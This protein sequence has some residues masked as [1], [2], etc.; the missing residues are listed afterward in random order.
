MDSLAGPLCRK[1]GKIDFD[2]EVLVTLAEVVRKSRSLKV[3]EF[4]C[5]NLGAEGFAFLGEAIPQ[6]KCLRTLAF[7]SCKLG[8]KA[9]TSLPSSYSVPSAAFSRTSHSGAPLSLPNHRPGAVG[10][11]GADA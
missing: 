10:A 5:C 2:D 9:C 1:F 11:F 3:L 8:P 6:A 7:K 4:D